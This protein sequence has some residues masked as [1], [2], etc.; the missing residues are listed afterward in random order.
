MISTSVDLSASIS[1]EPHVRSSPNLQSTLS[2]AVTRSY[3]GD[4]AI[5]YVLSA[6][7]NFLHG[8]YVTAA[9]P[10]SLQRP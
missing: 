7:T 8:L 10:T 1:Q 9:A 2:M 6:L 4:I 5:S 3:F